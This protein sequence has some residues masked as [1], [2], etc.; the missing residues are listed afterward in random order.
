MAISSAETNLLG[1]L[2]PEW[3]LL[4]QEWSSS[5][6]LT[7]AAQEALLLNGEPDALTELTDQWAAGVFSALPPVVLLS[8][9]AINGA[10]G[11]YALSTGTIYINADWLAVAS[12]EQVVAVLTEELGHHLDGVLNAV[13]TPGDEG[14]MLSWILNRGRTTSIASLTQENQINT[15]LIN[16]AGSKVDAEYASDPNTDTVLPVANG[17]QLTYDKTTNSFF[18][19]VSASD[20]GSGINRIEYGI[21]N[22]LGVQISGMQAILNTGTGLYE[23]TYSLPS[24]APDGLWS[25]TQIWIWDNAGNS[26]LYRGD[27]YADKVSAIPTTGTLLV[28][29]DAGSQTDA[30]LP[31]AN[32]LQLSYDKTTNS[33]FITVSASDI[34]SGINK[35]EYGITN[36][37]G[38]Q[39]SGMQAILN[40]GTGLYESTYSLPS[41]AP[42]GLWSLTQIWIWD[43]AGNSRL[44]RGDIYADKVSAIPT[45]GTLLIDRNPEAPTGLTLTSSGINENS[46]AGTVIGTLSATDPAAGSSFTYALVAGNGTNDADNALVE[47]VGNEVRVKSGAAIDFEN[48]PTLNLNIQVTDS[49]TPA[50]SLA[51]V[52]TVNVLDVAEGSTYNNIVLG[53]LNTNNTWNDIFRVDATINLYESVNATVVATPSGGTISNYSADGQ[54]ITILDKHDTAWI[55]NSAF[56]DTT[57][58][59]LHQNASLNQIEIGWNYSV[60]EDGANPGDDKFIVSGAFW[61]LDDRHIN[62]NFFSGSSNF[63]GGDG[64]DIYEI[65]AKSS[66]FKLYAE[67]REE[68]GYKYLQASLIYHGPESDASIWMNLFGVEEIRFADVTLKISD[69][70]DGKDLS[71]WSEIWKANTNNPPTDLILTSSGLAENSSTGTVIGTLAATDPDAGDTFTYALVAGNGTN[72]ADNAL[73]EIV[74]NEVLVKSSA[75]IDYE[76]NSILNLN[77]QVIDNGTPGLSFTKAVIAAV[78][79]ITSDDLPVI[80]LAVS[81]TAVSEDG[82]ANLVYL[83]TRTGSTTS[84]LSVNYTASGT[85]TIGTDYTGIAPSPST[86]TVT[87]AANSSTATVTV[88]PVADL[89]VE[90]DETVILT[91]AA[92]STYSVGTP[93]AVSGTIVNN[94]FRGTGNSNLTGT[95]Y[96]DNYFGVGVNNTFNGIAGY[97][98][99]FRSDGRSNYLIS[100]TV[101]TYGSAKIE[102]NTSGVVLLDTLINIESIQITSGNSNSRINAGGGRI[103][104]TGL[105]RS[106]YEGTLIAQGGLGF[107]VITGGSNRNWLAGGGL[108]AGAKG[109]DYLTG[110]TNISAGAIDYFD[111]RNSTNTAPAYVGQGNLD[112]ARIDKF[113]ATTDKLVL[114][115][116]LSDY[117]FKYVEVKLN[118]TTTV[119]DS[120]WSV[121]RSSDN[122]LIAQLRGDLSGFQPAGATVFGGGDHASF[123]FA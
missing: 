10:L 98:R 104:R 70:I 105:T 90:S 122:D 59:I 31:V 93:A 63:I 66:N 99:A 110:T 60:Y 115:G 57:K 76:T 112:Y 58:I 71:N 64:Y 86:K 106:A 54:D 100:G 2:L 56:N 80:S 26:R 117:R 120:Y 35:I 17:L 65:D 68:I 25:L 85:A 46:P 113:N 39:I 87:F 121:A 50:L 89:D 8:S 41:Q 29:R 51:K 83:F 79:N 62:G 49:G 47:I 77:I 27:I 33:F 24:Q 3:H 40:T 111:L 114:T 69:L 116:Q 32:G 78:I 16:V 82:T 4:L 6:R 61:E 48:N 67:D 43:N 38:V 45:T 92:G 18:I 22:P 42:D 91:L 102:D 13:D 34:G 15:G 74:G 81:P 88:D 95:I 12:N 73:V 119:T 75:S 44:Y 101:G 20:I 53:A 72:D 52:V 123:G 96:D 14:E 84:A 107:D 11:A 103:D 55:Y 5:G 19:A 28:S 9:S 97:D 7:A 23:S 109:I 37:L 1:A 118:N 30:I 36:P 94:D 108:A 21:T